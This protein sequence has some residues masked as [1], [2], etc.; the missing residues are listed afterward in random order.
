MQGPRKGFW[1]ASFA[2]S[3]MLAG[4]VAGLVFRQPAT[5]QAEAKLMIEPVRQGQLDGLTQA[6]SAGPVKSAEDYI[7]RQVALLKSNDLW[8]AAIR[9]AAPGDKSAAESITGLDVSRIDDSRIV[10]LRYKSMDPQTSAALVNA[11]TE[12]Y[13]SVRKRQDQDLAKLGTQ[14]LL[15]EISNLQQLIESKEAAR[16]TE[17]KQKEGSSLAANRKLL[18]QLLLRFREAEILQKE[19]MI[20]PAARIVTRATVPFKPTERPAVLYAL[21]AFIASFMLLGLGHL[22]SRLIFDRRQAGKPD[23]FEPG[24]LPVHVHLSI[25]PEEVGRKERPRQDEP[26]STI[27]VDPVP[28]L[29]WDILQKGLQR[30][31]FLSSGPAGSD[32]DIRQLAGQISEWGR[33]VIV[34]S[35]EMGTVEQVAGRRS[36]GLTDLVD[37][38]ADY[39]D[40]IEPDEATGCHRVRCGTRML[41]DRDFSDRRLHTF[42]MAL[43]SAYDVVLLDVGRLFDNSHA[44]ECLAATAHTHLAI[45]ANDEID[46]YEEEIR[47]Y[48][49][50]HG[51][52]D[53][54]IQMD[55]PTSS[56]AVMPSA[57]YEPQAAE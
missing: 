46:D 21:L 22:I 32:R 27:S 30:V 39:G 52:A 50:G 35:T 26:H 43:E 10:S 4:L 5:Y 56:P 38:C 29:A 15:K 3:A 11:L 54:T 18:E 25:E 36:I 34:I 24:E 16:K 57:C 2:L 14:R 47:T 41:L 37:S 53:V 1:I 33:S 9:K 20:A 51:F 23:C 44:M 49:K 55:K 45:L 48:F 17:A 7:E 31:V 8:G 28:L 6:T 19:D 13:L 12:T 42:L 40:I